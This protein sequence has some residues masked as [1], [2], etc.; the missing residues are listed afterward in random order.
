VID[1][2]QGP[3]EETE[4]LWWLTVAPAAW[5]A[6]LLASYATVAV[7]CAKVTDRDGALGD[8]RWMVAAYTA[9]A[10]ALIG[11]VAVHGFRR[12][13]FGEGVRPH[14][15]DTP[16]DRHRFLGF[17]TF[18]LAGVSAVATVYVSLV[19]VFIGSCQ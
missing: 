17:A 1:D 13:R 4:S 14:E 9:V 7:W 5:V 10:L 16:G 8:A 3:E 15:L 2:T 19:V 18:L 12:H 11:W 6:H